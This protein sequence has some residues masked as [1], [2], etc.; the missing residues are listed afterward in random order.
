MFVIEIKDAA[1]KCICRIPQHTRNISRNI[2]RIYLK[3]FIIL[4]IVIIN[5]TI[6]S[7]NVEQET[8]ITKNSVGNV[9]IGKKYSEFINYFEDNGF[10]MKRSRSGVQIYQDSIL[11]LKFSNKNWDDPPYIVKSIEVFSDRY[12]TS[13]NIS[14]GMTINDLL[15][16]YPDLELFLD[17]HSANFEYFQIPIY[18]TY[19]SDN[20]I[21]IAFIVIVSSLNNERLG[22][23]YKLKQSRTGYNGNIADNYNENGVISKIMIYQVR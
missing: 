20:S 2:G 14:I 13:D 9:T 3:K 11:V 21:K 23:N 5:T 6:W 17:G 22:V 10:N 16:I 8:I 7:Q 12:R 18:Q 4:L 1:N 15:L 19:D